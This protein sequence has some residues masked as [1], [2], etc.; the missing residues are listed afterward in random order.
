MAK[1]THDETFPVSGSSFSVANFNNAFNSVFQGDI[2][3]LRP[4]ASDVPG[5]SIVIAASEAQGYYRQTYSGYD[6]YNVSTSG[7]VTF[8]AP[9]SNPRIDLVHTSGTNGIIAIQ[10]SEAVSPVIPFM[11]SGLGYIPVC[12]VYHKTTETKIVDYE[13]QASNP[14]EGYI[15]RD[16]R[17]VVSV[18]TSTATKAVVW[19]IDGTVSTGAGQS[20]KVRIPYNGT[21]SRVD[22]T[23]DTAPTG[24]AILIDINK[25]TSSTNGTTIWSTQ[26]N[27]ATIIASATNGNTTTFNTTTITSGDWVSLDIDQVGSTIAG[28]DLTVIMTIS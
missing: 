28:S 2:A 23:V 6:S 27:R 11:P 14:D 4:R 26:A 5:M 3:P 20:A 9:S 10:G 18:P 12:A 8:T 1:C 16:L 21:I 22:L 13:D 19:Y 7:V 25:G 17:P 15:Y 24:A